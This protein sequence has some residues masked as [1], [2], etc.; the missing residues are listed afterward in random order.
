VILETWNSL[1]N[2]QAWAKSPEVHAAI[3]EAAVITTPVLL[4][5]EEA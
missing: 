3:K 1:A 5:L 2:A 4:F